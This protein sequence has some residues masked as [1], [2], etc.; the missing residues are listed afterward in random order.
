MSLGLPLSTSP[1]RL[2]SPPFSF[3]DTLRPATY[4]ATK[5]LAYLHSYKAHRHP[6]LARRLRH[7]QGLDFEL[8]ILPPATTI[9]LP[10]GRSECSSPSARSSHMQPMR[11]VVPPSGCIRL[12]RPYG[13]PSAFSSL[14][15]LSML[16]MCLSDL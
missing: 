11:C 1:C 7:H 3:V 8:V 16:L 6:T 13:S 10:F 5:I 15:T 4:P 9:Q 12:W 2:C 14:S